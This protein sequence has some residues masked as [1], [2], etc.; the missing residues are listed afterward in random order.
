[1]L[2][3]VFFSVFGKCT[4]NCDKCHILVGCLYRMCWLIHS[5]SGRVHTYLCACLCMNM[6]SGNTGPFCLYG[7]CLKVRGRVCVCACGL[8]WSRGGALSL[9]FVVEPSLAA[10]ICFFCA[11]VSWIISCWHLTQM[12][13]R[14]NILFGRSS[15]LASRQ[16]IC[17]WMHAVCREEWTMDSY[18]SGR[19]RTASFIVDVTRRRDAWDFMA[20]MIRITPLLNLVD[21]DCGPRRI[22]WLRSSPLLG[23]RFGGPLQI[24]SWPGNSAASSVD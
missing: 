17:S 5:L 14:H 7:K 3:N 13:Y 2:W 4:K 23:R 20:L 10:H 16:S 9:W 1:M 11:D 22:G 8:C 6:S 21:A 19:S 15:C 24:K 18:S 12:C